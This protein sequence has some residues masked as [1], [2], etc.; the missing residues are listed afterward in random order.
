MCVHQG[1]SY[2]AAASVPL[3]SCLLRDNHIYICSISVGPAQKL[4][5]TCIC[6]V[7]VDYKAVVTVQVEGAVWV[8]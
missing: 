4:I 8:R 5:P 6:V 2:R 3:G 1:V 7:T